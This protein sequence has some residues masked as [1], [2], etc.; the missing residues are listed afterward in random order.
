MRNPYIRIKTGNNKFKD[1]LQP[2][3]LFGRYSRW[4]HSVFRKYGIPGPPPT[5]FFGVF[6]RYIREVRLTFGV[7]GRDKVGIKY[8][9]QWAN[10]NIITVSLCWCISFTILSHGKVC[11]IIDTLCIKLLYNAMRFVCYAVKIDMNGLMIWYVTVC[12]EIW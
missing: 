7:G 5:P 8:I 3:C 11:N 10:N 12:F 2:F 4:K 6:L 9:F 1:A